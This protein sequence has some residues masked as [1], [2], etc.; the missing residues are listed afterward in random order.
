MT[1]SISWMLFGVGVDAPCS[2][3]LCSVL[4]SSVA[5]SAVPRGMQTDWFWSTGECFPSDGRSHGG[6]GRGGFYGV[7]EDNRCGRE[8]N[9]E[10]LWPF[11][12]FQVVLDIAEG[13]VV[14]KYHKKCVGGHFVNL[15]V[16]LII[17]KT[18]NWAHMMSHPPSPP[19]PL[20]SLPEGNQ[21]WRKVFPSSEHEEELPCG[22]RGLHGYG[23]HPQYPSDGR[24]ERPA[25]WVCTASHGTWGAGVAGHQWHGLWGPL[26]GHVGL[27]RALQELGDGDHPAA[28]W[29]PHAQLRRALHHSQR[30]VVRREL[31]GGE[32]LR[33]R[34]QHRLSRWRAPLTLF[35]HVARISCLIGGLRLRKNIYFTTL[36]FTIH[37]IIWG[38]K[39]RFSSRNQA[40]L[41]LNQQEQACYDSLTIP[42]FSVMALHENSPGSRPLKVWGLVSPSQEHN[43]PEH[44]K[45]FSITE[46]LYRK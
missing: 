41:L 6:C 30:Q 16:F 10:D 22:Q 24:W 38:C 1:I 27:Q 12:S 23:G 18:R 5:F 45:A 9:Q 32:G 46:W 39:I 43:Q 44:H 36:V 26:G 37:L 29:R 8:I 3:T 13:S 4:W 15:L 25:V 42:D 7:Q 21:D 14:D 2:I 31:Q 33:L 20:S 40:D 19:P 34:V 35:V 11:L 28:G 17:V